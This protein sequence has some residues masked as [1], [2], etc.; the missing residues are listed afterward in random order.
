[1]DVRFIAATNADLDRLTAR[2]EFRKDLY[3]RLKG[4]WLHL[5]PLRDRKE[6]IPLL[7]G[8]FMEEY[9]GGSSRVT[10]E[11]L[12]VLMA[13]EFPGNVRELQSILQSAANL[14]Q[15]RDLAPIW[16]PR[17]VSEIMEPPKGFSAHREIPLSPLAEMERTHILKAYENTGRNK[18]Q[19]AK[20]LGIGL[21]TLR[22]KLHQYET[23]S[24]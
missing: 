16:F 23:G 3:Y 4:A 20:L 8:R 2:G 18:T 14:A 12:S 9:D 24:S 5:P 6:D 15:G 17:H 1:V 13:Y 11:A 19:T 7:V 22:R 21:N 10:D